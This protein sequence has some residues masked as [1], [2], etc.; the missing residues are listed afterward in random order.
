MVAG[1]NWK[2]SANNAKLYSPYINSLY[3][4][5]WNQSVLCEDISLLA[6]LSLYFHIV[7]CISKYFPNVPLTVISCRLNTL[8]VL[9]S[10]TREKETRIV[11][12]KSHLIC[13]VWL[14]TATWWHLV[15]AENFILSSDLSYSPPCASLAWPTISTGQ[16]LSLKPTAVSFKPTRQSCWKLNEIRRKIKV[17]QAWNVFET[18]RFYPDLVWTLSKP[19]S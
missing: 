18:G 2:H 3:T 7:N 12:Y 13:Q 5:H 17:K 15:P 6:L 4:S 16:C 11:L 1:G 19:A 9:P 8:K 14:V 10:E